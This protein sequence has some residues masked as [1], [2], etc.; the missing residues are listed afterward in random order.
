MIVALAAADSFTQ[1]DYFDESQIKELEEV[2]IVAKRSE[3]REMREA[4]MPV[5]VVS[6]KQLEGTTTNIND[7]LARTTGV[8]VRNTGGVGSASRISVRG[9]EGKRM[10]IYIDEAAMGQFSDY[11]SFNDVPTDMIER[12]EIYKGI[13]PY[14]FGGSALGGAVNVVTYIHCTYGCASGSGS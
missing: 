3:I 12:I 7:A 9:L 13:V 11:M 1:G 10:G 6:V 4:A 14:R 5:S 2:S 8:T